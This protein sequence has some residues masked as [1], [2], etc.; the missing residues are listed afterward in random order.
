[1]DGDKQVIKIAEVI[2]AAEHGGQCLSH[3]DFSCDVKC[4]SYAKALCNKGYHTTIWHKLADNDLPQRVGLYLCYVRIVGYDRHNKLID[5]YGYSV[6]FFD[7]GFCTLNK[8]V[9][10]WAELPEYEEREI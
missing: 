8:S 10:A 3:C 7:A 5:G 9:I 4:L 2:C 1:M 6:E